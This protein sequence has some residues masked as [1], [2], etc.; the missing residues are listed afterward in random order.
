MPDVTTPIPHPKRTKILLLMTLIFGIIAI[1]FLFYWWKWGR[2]DEYTDDAYVTGNLV[3]VTPQVSGIVTS[4]YADNTWFVEKEQVLIQLDPTDF[5]IALDQSKAD[6]AQT[7]RQ[8]AKL[9]AQT[10]QSKAQIRVAK[11]TF[12]KTAEDYERREALIASGSVSQEDLTHSI[13]AMTSAYFR[14]I[15][16]EQ[17]Y[18]SLLAQVEN[19]T[20]E[21]HPLV[22]QA[23][24]KLK[25]TWI[26]LKRTTIK[27]PTN[28][29]IAQR[30]AQVGERVNPSEPLLAVV[31]VNEIWIEANYKE[32]QIGHMQ[33]GQRATIRTDIYGRSIV[34]DGEIVGIG[35]GT[36]S[37]F[38]LLPPQNAT[39]NWIKIVQ[40]VP[41]R[42]SL[43]IEK[44]LDHPLR[45]GLSAEVHVDIHPLENPAPAQTALTTALYTTAIF[46]DE[47]NGVEDIINTILQENLPSFNGEL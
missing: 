40:R 30:K 16:A 7:V 39:G 42:I 21:T 9:F 35:G 17:N 46:A 47:E 41:V 8:V 11:S 27:A 25:T 12:I 38:S 22:K 23:I 15:A 10:R 3:Y 43:P 13:A 34:Y 2:F 45:L 26:D 1:S 31:P 19:T 6:L 37:V 28:G 4:I 33:I 20:I 36:G 24:Q 5:V 18:L 14:L 32:D 44:I 29:I